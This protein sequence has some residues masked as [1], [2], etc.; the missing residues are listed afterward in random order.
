MKPL[1]AVLPGRQ[2]PRGR[3]ISSWALGCPSKQ[4]ADA[5]HCSTE[6]Q[7]HTD[8]GSLL[9]SLHVG[10]NRLQGKVGVHIHQ[11][12]MRWSHRKVSRENAFTFEPRKEPW[13]GRRRVPGLLATWEKRKQ[14]KCPHFFQKF[15]LWVSLA[16]LSHCIQQIDR[17]K[18]KLYLSPDL[19]PQ[20]LPHWI[21]GPLVN[22][23]PPLGKEAKK[24]G[25]REACGDRSPS[26]RCP[27]NSFD[28]K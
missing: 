3:F 10:P 27:Q 6:S 24:K 19:S 20:W 16:V 1:Q 2:I 25:I 21:P 15:M 17:G 4:N 18:E 26:F 28:N 8:G 14:R 22:H 12:S 13:Q 5:W 23:I 7:L 11:C 9:T